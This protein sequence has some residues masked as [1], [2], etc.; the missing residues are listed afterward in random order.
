MAFTSQDERFMQR[1]LALARR[2]LGKTSPNPAVGAVL[3]RKGLVV[4]E[5]WHKRAGGPHAEVFALRNAKARGATLYVTMEPCSTWEKTPPC[6]G[7]IIAAG[8]KRVV[9]AARDPNP[10]HNGRGLTVLRRAGIRVEAGLLAAEAT[11]LN[12][13]FN[14]WITTGMP[15]VIAKAAMSL[16]GKIA[17]RTGDSKW[18]TSE[19]ARREAHKLRAHV[20]AIMVGA[21]AVI[22]DDPQL[23]VRHGVRGKQPCR[24]V[25]DGH[26]RSPR[27]AKLFTDAHR[28]RTIVLT[29]SR[30][31]PSW[32]KN[33]G[34]SGVHVFVI[35]GSGGRLDLRAA[36]RVLGKMNITSVLVEGGGELLG[37]L[38]DARLIDR[39][40]LF[41]AP[42]VI[43]GRGAVTTVGGEGVSK[44][45]QSVRFLDC[46]WRNIGKDEILVEARVR[47]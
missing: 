21:N 10:K 38:F 29:T 19:T 12:E 24:V 32:R 47:K 30:S 43:G 11:A 31:S 13:A 26:G 22:R 42:I 36:L 6:T 34:Q 33:L 44:V 7:A 18:I 23:T 3:V 17:T 25:V 5:G 20:D 39:V 37:S 9:V 2:G 16:D 14:K 41:Y 1:A 28:Q 45:K 35:K 15:L 27:T 4:A 40:A 46:H 8:V